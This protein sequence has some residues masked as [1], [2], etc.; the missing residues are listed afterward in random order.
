MGI[1]DRTIVCL[2]A[3]VLVG[4]L[5]VSGC[6]A[7]QPKIVVDENGLR[8]RSDAGSFRALKAKYDALQKATNAR[9]LTVEGGESIGSASRALVKAGSNV[10]YQQCMSFFKT[11]GTEQQYLLFT[12]DI[13]GVAGTIATGVLGLTNAGATATAALGIGSGAAL[14][15]ISIYSRNFLFSEDNVQA[16]QDL[17]LK[18]LNEAAQAAVSPDRGDYDFDTAVTAIMDVQSNCEV[19]KI[20]SLVRQSISGA[21]P[22]ATATP[23]GRIGVIVPL[24]TVTLPA[25]TVNDQRQLPVV[26]DLG[27]RVK[28]LSDRQ[29]LVLVDRMAPIVEANATP[30]AI[31]FKQLRPNWRTNPRNARTLFRQL[32]SNAPGPLGPWSSAISAAEQTPK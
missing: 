3:P 30:A 9:S 18:A 12:R 23:N 32:L 15:G 5:L 24:Q 2:R 17:T 11:A 1:I 14:S 4:S 16:V 8:N 29:M 7:Y 6:T 20:L 21:Q 31:G 10:A 22:V 13:V 25:A 19:Q 26:S 27:T 28:N